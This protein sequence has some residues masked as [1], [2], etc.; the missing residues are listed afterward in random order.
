MDTI[1]TAILTAL[2]KLS[3]TVVKEG[4]EALKA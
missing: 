3:G 1:L 2:G 4:Y